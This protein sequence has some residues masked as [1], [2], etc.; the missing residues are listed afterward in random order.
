MQISEE[1]VPS[2]IL[3][4]YQPRSSLLASALLRLGH[5]LMLM[6]SRK[7]GGGS[8]AEGSR[9]EVM[10]RAQQCFKEGLDVMQE[11]GQFDPSL[12]AELLIGNGE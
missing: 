4:A 7:T 12:L 9:R 5:T 2:I 6:A 8:E 3:N 11:C 10:E 1:Q